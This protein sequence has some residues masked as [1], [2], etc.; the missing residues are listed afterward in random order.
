METQALKRTIYVAAATGSAEEIARAEKW[1]TRL[2]EAGVTVISDWLETIKL[3]G[4]AN[5]MEASREYRMSRANAP[6]NQVSQAQAFWLLM[7]EDTATVGAYVEF[8]FALAL[9]A[10]SQ[11]A[12]AQGILERQRWVL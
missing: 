4:G 11:L 2:R 1:M 10:M 5:P 7:P 8:G 12:L 6:L 9:A 3:P